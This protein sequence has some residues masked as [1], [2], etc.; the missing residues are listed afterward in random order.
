MYLG[1]PYRWRILKMKRITKCPYCGAK[2]E[3]KSAYDIYHTNKSKDYGLVYVCSNYPICDSYVGCHKNSDRPLGRLANPRLRSLKSEAHKQF[4]KLWKKKI[5]SRR[6]AYKWLS[7]AL[8][9]PIEEC[10]IGMFDVN[11]CKKV[12]YLCKNL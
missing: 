8:D 9:I 12:V 3:L 2:V 6:E 1:R 4:D 10:H 5:M 11:M 7:V